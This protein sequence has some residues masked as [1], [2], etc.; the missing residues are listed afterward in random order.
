MSYLN[1]YEDDY[2]DLPYYDDDDE[3]DDD[4]R[5]Y[6]GESDRERFVL[7]VGMV[8]QSHLNNRPY[9]RL[10]PR[11]YSQYSPRDSHQYIEEDF[12]A[13]YLGAYSSKS[14]NNSSHSYP[15]TSTN[16]AD[17]DYLRRQGEQRLL[18][19]THSTPISVG[20]SSPRR[21]ESTHFP[22]PQPQQS[23]DYKSGNS[24]KLPTSSAYSKSTSNMSS[25]PYTSTSTP[26]GGGKD[27]LS[28]GSRYTSSLLLSSQR[29]NNSPLN[30]PRDSARRAPP[31]PFL[32]RTESRNAGGAPD[33]G[34]SVSLTTRHHVTPPKPE[35]KL[36]KAPASTTLN[37]TL[38]TRLS[39][40]TSR[41]ATPQQTQPDQQPL[42]GS[43]SRPSTIKP[44]TKVIAVSSKKKEQ[45]PD[46]VPGHNNATSTNNNNENSNGSKK[47][48][49]QVVGPAAPAPK[50]ES[51]S[52]IV[53]AKPGTT[54]NVKQ[55]K[56]TSNSITRNAGSANA[57]AQINRNSS[58]P[59]RARKSSTSNQNNN[60]N[61]KPNAAQQ[62][63]SQQSE[64]RQASNSFD[65]TDPIYCWVVEYNKNL[66]SAKMEEL[67]HDHKP[68]DQPVKPDSAVMQP[69]TTKQ[70]H[71]HRNVPDKPSADRWRNGNGISS[72]KNESD[73]QE[74]K[75]V[76]VCSVSTEVVRQN[77]NQA[78]ITVITMTHINNFSRK[79][80]AEQSQTGRGS[81]SGKS[82]AGS[83][84]E[85]Q[86]HEEQL[87]E[88]EFYLFNQIDEMENRM[89]FPHVYPS[90]ENARSNSQTSGC[91]IPSFCS[92]GTNDSNRDKS[93]LQLTIG[94]GVTSGEATKGNSGSSTISNS[95]RSVLSEQLNI[96]AD[97]LLTLEKNSAPRKSMMSEKT[98]KM[99]NVNGTSNVPTDV[100]KQTAARARTP[101]NS[102]KVKATPAE[103][104]SSR[105]V[106]PGRP[107][108]PSQRAMSPFRRASGVSGGFLTLSK[109]PPSSPYN[110]YSAQREREREREQM[111]RSQRNSF[112]TNDLFAVSLSNIGHRSDDARSE[113]D[114][115]LNASFHPSK[116]EYKFNSYDDLVGY[117]SSYEQG[118]Y[119]E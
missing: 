33:F 80:S 91:S 67:N 43:S 27:L 31:Q 71:Q 118:G 94:H 55:N 106:Q 12:T 46:D 82:G 57:P 64:S 97:K 119:Y 110:Y 14:Y 90:I 112:R 4:G 20:M 108:T 76:E 26:S 32:S 103:K 66:K 101:T 114:L 98:A 35:E 74:A 19:A 96:I 117:Y 83:V 109:D 62:Q 72:D 29:R 70:Q 65:V 7:G 61:D 116:A 30:S 52:Y 79:R 47:L 77:I 113:Y 69:S 36:T 3:E 88:L 16:D 50:Q 37:G 18:M 63:V 85:S 99:K 59:V 28:S 45:Q 2:D 44:A 11:H 92:V 10:G 100:K 41:P 81:N 75:C 56:P 89:L 39:V 51:A 102:N 78:I 23:Y 60:N 22:L 87:S 104:A 1:F 17:F 5:S 9:D 105:Q 53:D 68:F 13:D 38:R 48:R 93:A 42:A 107:T 49:R 111:N 8:G 73:G 25:K 24:S 21:L 40:G 6:G 115:K 86:L 84:L 95:S 15:Y 54:K 34:A 58:T